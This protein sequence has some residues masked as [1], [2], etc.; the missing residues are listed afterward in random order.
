MDNDEY[1]DELSDDEEEYGNDEVGPSSPSLSNVTKNKIGSI[2][3]SEE[4]RRQLERK[5]IKYVPKEY[6][7]PMKSY[8]SDL[9]RIEKEKTNNR[10][11]HSF[12]DLMA[13]THT[14]VVDMDMTINVPLIFTLL[15]IL[16]LP[17]PATGRRSSKVKMPFPGPKYAGCIISM[18]YWGFNR[19]IKRKSK[20]GQ[21]FLN[22]ITLDIVVSIKTINV[23]VSGNS[24]H[25]CGVK[26]MDNVD[27]LIGLL[28]S[29]LDYIQE[30]FF[31]I[32][33]EQEDALQAAIDEYIE[34]AKGDP[35]YSQTDEEQGYPQGATEHDAT[36][37]CSND[38]IRDQIP[39]D[40][41]VKTVPLPVLAEGEPLETLIDKL[42]YL[43]HPIMEPDDDSMKLPTISVLRENIEWIMKQEFV[44]TGSFTP[45]NTSIS[46]V[47]YSFHLPFP[48][49]RE[50]IAYL[51]DGYKEFKGIYIMGIHKDA[52]I[53]HPCK[54]TGKELLH[55]KKKTPCNKFKVSQTGSIVQSGPGTK[56]MEEVFNC[57]VKRIID[58]YDVVYLDMP[59]SLVKRQTK[60]RDNVR[61]VLDIF[62]MTFK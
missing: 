44:Y 49:N 16:H 45:T 43:L 20:S 32:K 23:K 10:F 6:R 55:R 29:Q 38:R 12:K 33:Q 19:G 18:C 42:R 48:A 11:I 58:Y 59:H 57:F 21:S 17:R 5:G 3:D 39:V 56:D 26:T 36:T 34:M 41:T 50:A 13:T 54:L 28:K 25:M 4:L 40:W 1:D 24:F 15:P 61:Q 30:L 27:E 14:V 53:D 51:F 31:S 7:G 47:N 46:M 8:L 2:V 22:T 37:A 60:R 35:I 62:S 9:A 52:V